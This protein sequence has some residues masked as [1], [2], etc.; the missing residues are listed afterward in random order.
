[1]K[2]LKIVVI[3]VV[4]AALFNYFRPLPRASA[5]F[6]SLSASSPPIS[7]ITWPKVKQSAVGAVGLGP[8]ANSGNQKPVPI[9]SIA[10]LMTA[11]AVLKQKPISDLTPM[12]SITFHQSDIDLYNKY[13]AEDGS[14][15]PIKVGQKMTEFQALQAMLIPS[16]NNIADSLAIWTFGSIKAYTAYANRLA[17]DYKMT[18][19]H[20]NDASGFS[21]K[22]TSSAN[23]L[24]TL[25]Q[26]VMQDP[27]LSKIVGQKQL[28]LPI[29]G[30]I[31]NTNKLLG[32]GG[33]SGIKTGNTDEAGGCYLFAFNKTIGGQPITILGAIL[34]AKDLETALNDAPTVI[35]QTKSSF[36]FNE[37]KAGSQPVGQYKSA[38]GSIAGIVTDASVPEITWPGQAPQVTFQANTVHTSAKTGQK[39]G[40]VS[41]VNADNTVTAN[42]KLSSDLKGPSF[43]WRLFRL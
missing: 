37:I 12:P 40:R 18:N 3:L 25:G 38:W 9:A 24:I 2:Y 36:I 42:L 30:K 19:T 28:R 14:V 27:V 20:I 6:Y 33:V 26:V 34:G 21:A 41:A 15:V 17:A 35:E 39:I 7:T 23:D 13:L 43:S 16:A 11:V 29:A 10:K 31:T 1:M 8:L 32:I 5:N 4:I 22:T